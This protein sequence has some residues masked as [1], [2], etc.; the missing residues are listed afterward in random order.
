M[1]PIPQYPIYSA[2]LTLLGGQGIGYY[3]D[4][5]KGWDLNFREVERSFLEARD[6]GVRVVA[7]VLINPGNPTGQVLSQSTLREICQ[8]CAEH[9]LVGP[10]CRCQCNRSAFQH[11]TQR[12][13]CSVVALFL[14]IGTTC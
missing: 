9:K 12:T 6:R 10:I 4:E 2:S 5:A 1:I 3:L 13:C 7:M 11:L 8:F 14:Y